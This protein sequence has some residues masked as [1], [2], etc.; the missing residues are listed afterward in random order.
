M[1]DKVTLYIATHNITGKKY[2]GKTICFFTKEDLQKKYHGS[3][4]YWK[5]HLQKHGDEVTM[6]IYGIFSLNVSDE[7]YVEPIALK[8]SEE[9]N[10]VESTD[11][12]NLVAENGKD[13]NKG[14][15]TLEAIENWKE[16][17]YS[18]KSILKNKTSRIEAT[19]KRLIT[20]STEEYKLKHK[21]PLL[22]GAKKQKITKATEEYKLKNNGKN[23][24]STKTILIYNYKNELSYICEGSFIDFCNK[25]NL[26]NTALRRSFENNTK[27]YQTIN[28]KIMANKYGFLHLIGWYAKIA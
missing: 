16:S 25:H 9:N 26:P 13:G 15:Q 24:Y 5:K 7:D 12:A 19:A 10:I 18:E 23:H 22:N 28:G 14:M 3:G 11:W 2:F 21:E 17:R 8:F 4:V 6:E 27:L 20:I 1:E